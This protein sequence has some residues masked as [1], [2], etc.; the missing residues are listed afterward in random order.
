MTLYLG[1]IR[2]HLLYYGCTH[3]TADIVLS[4]PEENITV[5]AGIFYPN[6][7]PIVGKESENATTSIVENWFVVM[8]KILNEA[9][10]NTQFFA[11]H[12]RA[13]MKKEQILQFVSYVEELWNKIRLAKAGGKTLDQVKTELLLKEFPEV[14]KLP[15][16]KFV[17]SQWEILDIHKQNIEHLWKVL[18]K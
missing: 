14:A 11:S 12:H 15:N 5:T 18:E 16:E 1:D 9:N 4:M 17:G 6:N 8:H 7:V 10:E 13:I 3:G 2:M